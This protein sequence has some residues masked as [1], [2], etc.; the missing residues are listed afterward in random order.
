MTTH[1]FAAGDRV[2]VRADGNNPGI[3]PGT[4]TITRTMPVSSMGRQYRV[5]NALDQQ[6]RVLEE[7]QLQKG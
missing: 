4:Y 6:E 1:K 2:L 5:K 7:A 3:R